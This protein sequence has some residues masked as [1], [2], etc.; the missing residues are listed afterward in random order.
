M[1]VAVIGT[2]GYG[3]IE[4]L[5]ILHSHPVFQIQSIHSTKGEVPIWKEYPHL[6]N[7]ND[8]VL[9]VINPEEIAEKSDLVFLATPSGV[10]GQLAAQFAEFNIKLVDLSGDLR[11]KNTDEYTQWYKHEA[12]PKEIIDKAVYGLTEWRREQVAGAQW[13][14]N[15]GCY[16]T[17]SLLG[18]G[19]I[20]KE[21][22]IDPSSII[23][24]AKSGTSGAGRKPTRTTMHA[25]MSENFKIYKVNEHQHIPEIEQQLLEWNEE[26]KPIT[27]ST[28]LLPISRGIMATIYV[29]VQ[30]GVT[31]SEIYK[32]YEEHYQNDSFVR[33]RPEGHYPAVK[34]VCGSNFCDIG[35][36]LDERTGRLTIV[37]V[38]DNLMKGAAGQ[39]V[40]NAN[41]MTGLDETTGLTFIPMYP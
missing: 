7:I 29:Q 30:K 11:L 35:L 3:G 39:A 25:E 23:I 13:I 28:H 12:A 18:L 15:P 41:I 33:V 2:T 21:K 27:F 40:Q 36:H 38:I 10:S 31:L 22:L 16:S 19:P 34:E 14:S 20:V 24:D 8:Q 37:S 32:I 1:K 26:I 6:F 4:L 9:E 17:A 5:R